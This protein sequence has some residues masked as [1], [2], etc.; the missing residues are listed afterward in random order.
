MSCDLLL[1]CPH[2]QGTVIVH[3][4][5]LHCRIFRHAVLRSTGEP[6]HP[7]ASRE[8]CDHL[9]AT[10]AILGCGK[11]FRVERSQDGTEHAIACDYI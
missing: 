1:T 11:P 8:E 5:E 6:L 2:C 7:H 9:A 4:S 3:P 10:G